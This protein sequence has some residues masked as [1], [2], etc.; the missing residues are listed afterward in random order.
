MIGR[1]ERRKEDTRK[2]RMAEQRK[3]VVMVTISISV[4]RPN[5]L[6]IS[7]PKPYLRTQDKVYRC[8]MATK[9]I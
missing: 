4:G 7:C 8:V 5:G 3:D 2:R 9:S 6:Y 1:K